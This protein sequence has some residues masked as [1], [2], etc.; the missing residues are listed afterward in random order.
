MIEYRWYSEKT[1]ISADLSAG[2][3]SAIRN[4]DIRPADKSADI[5]KTDNPPNGHGSGVDPR[6]FQVWLTFQPIQPFEPT[7]IILV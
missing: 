6:P 7:V 1:D 4:A 3:I 2:R 5:R